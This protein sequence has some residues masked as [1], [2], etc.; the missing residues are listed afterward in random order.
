MVKNNLEKLLL[1][2]EIRG[3]WEILFNKPVLFLLKK[4]S[5]KGNGEPIII[6]PGFKTGDWITENLRRF[7][8]E[9]NYTVYGWEGGNNNGY[10]DKVDKH[11]QEHLEKIYQKHRE[12]ICLVGWSLGG[13]YARELSRTY[14]DYIKMVV[15][16]G[17]PFN[18]IEKG[19]NIW[20]IFR[21]MK[22]K[23]KNIDP[24]IKKKLPDPLP[25]PSVSIFSK[26]DSVAWSNACRAK[27]KRTKNFQITG[28]HI[29]LPF[30][31]KVYKIIVKN[32]QQLS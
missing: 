12:K 7:L 5:L 26:Y 15:S 4:T 3:F 21:E 1:L 10:N 9:L 13:I 19:V 28:S 8:S 18:D 22:E 30:N 2:F 31:Y 20:W 27:D 17:S 16:I 11:L 25:V 29:G 32:L 14:P 23:I 24:K 6:Y